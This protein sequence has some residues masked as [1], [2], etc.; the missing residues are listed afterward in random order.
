LIELILEV[1]RAAGGNF[2]AGRDEAGLLRQRGLEPQ[3]RAEVVTLAPGHP[4]LRLPLQ[5]AT[6]LEPRLLS[7]VDIDELARLRDA[8]DTELTDPQRWGTTFTL[9]QTWAKGDL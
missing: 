1:F 5:F 4:Y 2:E 3:T 6:P 9:V 8:A 7:L